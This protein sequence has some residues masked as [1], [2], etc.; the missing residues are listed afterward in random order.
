M[1]LSNFKSMDTNMLL[2]IVNMKLRNEF[3]SIDS[4]CSYYEI[5][6]PE[7]LDKLSASGYHYNVC[8]NQFK[9]EETNK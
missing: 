7:L 1:Q 8:S 5:E 2:S 9:A 4:L 3:D 6:Q